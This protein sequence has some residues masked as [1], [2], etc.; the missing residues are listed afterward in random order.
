MEP[1]TT[2]CGGD[3]NLQDGCG[4]VFDRLPHTEVLCQL[5][6]RLKQPGMSRA[7]IDVLRVSSIICNIEL[8]TTQ[9]Q[10]SGL[11]NSM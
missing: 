9:A 7:E 8:L 10:S 11:A 6:K 3:N 5:C 2:P 4:R 1:N